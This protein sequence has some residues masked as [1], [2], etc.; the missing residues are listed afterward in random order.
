MKVNKDHIKKAL[1]SKV[2]AWDK[3]ELWQDIEAKLPPKKEKKRSVLLWFFIPGFLAAIFFG[4]SL[5]S[6][7]N[8]LFFG[9]VQAYESDVSVASENITPDKLYNSADNSEAKSELKNNS[10]LV[11]KT[12][13]SSYP[14]VAVSSK[15]TSQRSVPT[16]GLSVPF[17]IQLVTTEYP[18]AGQTNH[19][20]PLDAKSLLKNDSDP[21]HQVQESEVFIPLASLS[22]QSKEL[23]SNNMY[24][25]PM[26]AF[27]S[28]PISKPSWK[29]GLDTEVALL[30]STLSTGSV[31]NANWKANK[32]KVNQNKESVAFT[33]LLQKN[34]TSKCWLGFGLQ[35]LRMN[36]VL[37]A[38]DVS[39]T[40]KNI[41][42][43]S[44]QFVNSS[45]GVIYIPGTLKQ[46]QTKG[47][48]IYSP[49]VW[50]RWSIPI[51]LSY[52]IPLGKLVL[53]PN[54]TVT[55]AFHQHFQGIQLHPN[56]SYI[57]KNEAL[58]KTLYKNANL[59]SLGLGLESEF[60]L[61]PELRLNTGLF[62]TTDVNS[63]WNGEFA[64]QEKFSQTG[65]RLGL[66]Y[67]W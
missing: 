30:N 9:P 61:S 27:I 8:H 26:I 4:T 31:D 53:A 34:I 6:H 63:V 40:I 29:L 11:T 41:Q 43:D 64:I 65:I 22:R 60:A 7:L 32:T 3:E 45:S 46:T 5:Y 28:K 18:V 58:F 37:T 66:S 50:T 48:A 44:A 16:Q 14:G 17:P 47:Y 1:D 25:L 42:S 10:I 62:Y 56:G 12:A 52:Q 55:Y 57:Y 51:R 54:A 59:V 20:H 33:M 23:Q 24:L 19:A 13:L 35:Y 67:V 38:Q 2:P 36:E 49:N 15:N 21:N 39:T